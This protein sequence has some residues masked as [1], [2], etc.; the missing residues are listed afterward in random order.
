M[1]RIRRTFTTLCISLGLG[2]AGSMCLADEGVDA[3]FQRNIG[4][5]YRLYTQQLNQYPELNGRVDFR[6]TVLESGKP[7]SCKIMFS[8][9]NLPPF[10]NRLCASIMSLRFPP[11]EE[12]LLV[13][14]SVSFD[15][16]GGMPRTN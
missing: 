10:E 15:P 12:P 13:Q 4:K 5:M 6:F 9:L 2:L 7:M 8:E 3:E 14:K 1:T 11:R 16:H